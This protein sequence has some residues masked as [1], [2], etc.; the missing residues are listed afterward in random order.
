MY[1][2]KKIIIHIHGGEIT[3]GS[4]DDSIRHSISKLSRFHFVTSNSA[5]QILLRMGE[6]KN[7]IFN[8]GSLGAENVKNINVLDKNVLFKKLR[9]NPEL[10]TCLLVMQPITNQDFNLNLNFNKIIKF[11]INNKFNQLLVSKINNDPGSADMVN[12]F[13]NADNENLNIKLLETLGLENYISLAKHADLVI[14][15]SSS[16]IFEFPLKNIKSILLTNRP[17]NK[18]YKAQPKR[19]T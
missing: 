14:G 5:E 3:Q 17:N 9:I 1:L 6:Q 2:I 7:N 13:L 16:F 4:W 11:L 8:Y 19:C 12:Y 18:T 10:K 15:N